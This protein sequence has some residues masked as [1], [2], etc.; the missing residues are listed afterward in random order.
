MP[1]SERLTKLNESSGAEI[2]TRVPASLHPDQVANLG[3]ILVDAEGSGPTI[4][5]YGAARHALRSLYDSAKAID[6][7]HA[8]MLRPEPVV[9]MQ[10]AKGSAPIL[11][12]V[13]P[14]A[15]APELASAMASAASRT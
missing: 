6:T 8:S 1:A 2:S 3:S 14:K 5:A 7:A 13:I 12:M 15:S 4:D 9:S 11:R 10:A